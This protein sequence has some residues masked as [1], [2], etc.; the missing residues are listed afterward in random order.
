MGDF[1]WRAF[2]KG[3]PSW[4]VVLAAV[5]NGIVLSCCVVGCHFRQAW[6]VLI[7]FHASGHPGNVRVIRFSGNVFL[8]QGE[9]AVFLSY[10]LK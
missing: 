4:A 5:S 3:L 8:I 1:I 9:G 6:L 2:I 7:S 10:K